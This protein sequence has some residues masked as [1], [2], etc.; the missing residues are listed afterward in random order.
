MKKILIGLA[1]SALLLISGCSK[2]DQPLEMPAVN[3]IRN[4]CDLATLDCYYHNVAKSKK[5]AGGGFLAIG[6]KDRF[7]WIEYTGIVRLGIDFSKVEMSVEE[8]LVRITM[9]EAK[10]L[11]V[12]VDENSIDENSYIASK[13]GFNSNKITAEDQIEAIKKAQ[14]E[15][16]ETVQKNKMLLLSAENRAKSL[17]ENYITRLG[18]ATGVTYHVVWVNVGELTNEY[19]TQSTTSEEAA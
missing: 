11:S 18:E 7:F 17:I 15:M 6:E 3:Q 13:D 19:S 16:E 4:I 8:N 2:K 1:V 14:I 5:E 10:I 9:P 12:S